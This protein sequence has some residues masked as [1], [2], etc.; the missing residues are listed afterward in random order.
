M[1]ENASDNLQ[2]LH[3]TP[4]RS[5]S[6]SEP[7]L[8]FQNNSERIKAL[9]KVL[10]HS[11]ISKNASEPSEI[12]RTAQNLQKRLITPH[13]TP[14]HLL[15]VKEQLRTIG[16]LYELLK[17]YSAVNA[18]ETFWNVSK[19]LRTDNN[20][21]DHVRTLQNVRQPLRTFIECFTSSQNPWDASNCLTT[22]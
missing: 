9:Q 11:R 8:T 17:T 20:A 4:R 1:L 6:P 7:V 12:F 2:K 14:E 22:Y 10:E 19:P 13:N 3:D 21:L 5:E 15:N 16:N 18:S